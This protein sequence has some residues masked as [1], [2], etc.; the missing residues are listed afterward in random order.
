VK[1]AELR[2][3]A[4]DCPPLQ[5]WI[6]SEPA[7]TSIEG[8]RSRPASFGDVDSGALARRVQAPGWLDRWLA[9]Q[10]QRTIGRAGI[11]LELWDGSSPG[12]PTGSIGDLVVKDRGALIGL[13]VN[14]DLQFG[15]TYASGRSEI[16]GDLRQVLEAL[17]RL[18]TVFRASLRERLALWLA[19]ANNLLS[20]RRNARYHYD[21]GN[22]FY[23]LWLDSQLVYTCAYYPEP[24]STLESAQIAKLDL[25]CRKLQLQPGERVLEAGCGWGALALHMARHYGVSVKAFN[26]SVEQI[27]FARERAAREG[28]ADRVEFIEDDYRNATGMFDVAV[29]IGMLEHVGRKNYSVLAD[30][31]RRTLKRDTGRGLLHFIGRDRPRPLNAWI[32]RRIFPGAYPPALGEVLTHIIEPADMSVLDVENLRLHYART[33][34]HWRERFERSEARIRGTLGDQFYRAWQLYLAGSEA[35]FAT[36]WLQLFQVVFAHSWGRTTGWTRAGLYQDA[37][38][39]I[40]NGKWAMGNGKNLSNLPWPISHFPSGRLFSAACY[41]PPERNP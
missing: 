15:E 10:L 7:A 14:P 23:Q 21:L 33:L 22:D 29:S 19:P 1:G 6:A 9:G 8:Q 34:A 11:R 41:T 37:E 17:C 40:L 30:V 12:L 13:I 18:D 39:R 31:L 35:T 26:V 32:R 27:R 2:S 28:L 36:G 16:R 4:Q 38:R 24:D 3:N 5:S 20:S 25:V